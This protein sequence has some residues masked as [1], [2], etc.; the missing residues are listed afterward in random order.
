MSM[1]DNKYV[2]AAQEDF[3][4]LKTKWN[5][6]RER[7]FDTGGDNGSGDGK[8]E[9]KFAE[10]AWSDFKEQSEKIRAAG[11]TAS[12]ELRG[13]YEAARDKV[14]KVVEAYQRG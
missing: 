7:M 8:P 5:D 13:S 4:A 3:D 2:Q 10:T 11:S 12:S 6:V 14:R 1:Q 9:S